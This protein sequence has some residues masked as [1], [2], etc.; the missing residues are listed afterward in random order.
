MMGTSYAKERCSVKRNL[1]QLLLVLA[2]CFSFGV[3]APQ[4]AEAADTYIGEWSE[5][6]VYFDP[7]TLMGAQDQFATIWGVKFVQ[8]GNTAASALVKFMNEDGV[9]WTSTMLDTQF[10]PGSAV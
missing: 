3:L 2:L 4:P 1:K 5:Y 8:D 9:W 6:Q 10:G 7:D